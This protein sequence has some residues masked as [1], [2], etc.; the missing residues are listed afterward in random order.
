MD[1][2]VKQVCWACTAVRGGAAK[3]ANVNANKS[4]SKVFFKANSLGSDELR[5]RSNLL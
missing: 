4:K 2:W 5:S 3:T 1:L